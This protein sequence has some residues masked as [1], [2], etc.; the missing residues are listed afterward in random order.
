MRICAA[1]IIAVLAISLAGC[2][3]NLIPTVHAGASTIKSQLEAGGLV[4]LAPGTYTMG[5]ADEAL[6]TKSSHIVG[7]SRNDTVL[8]DTCTN[9]S[10]T[11]SVDLTNSITV[12]IESIQINHVG[13]AGIA[14]H[15]GVYNPGG[16]LVDYLP[17]LDH[18]LRI[19]SAKLT[20]GGSTPCLTTEGLN[21]F[22]MERS[23]VVGCG[24]DGAEIGSFGVNLTNNWFAH[25]G[26]NGVTF[27][28]AGFCGTC[29]GN[30]YF[31][32][33]GNGVEYANTATADPRHVAD[34]ADSNGGFGLV[35]NGVRD[36]GWNAGWIGNN[37]AG[38]A[39][40]GST[41][42][43]GTSIVGT[44]FANNFGTDL[45]V[46]TQAGPL[47]TTGSYSANPQFSGCNALI[48]GAC[49]NLNQ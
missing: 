39:L 17:M 31:Y 10:P 18:E 2:G 33:A 14:L 8:L 6:I 26:H 3:R 1:V 43:M 7:N 36:F 35:V 20:G 11:L 44:T 16:V 41:G 38:G 32:N 13:G 40:V 42:L 30:Q 12:T 22:F 49:V 48:A 47:R 28:G 23:I 24:G 34:F 46:N 21:L 37:T 4:N 19:V 45:K 25:N 29:I 27:V 5:C 15:G 9:G